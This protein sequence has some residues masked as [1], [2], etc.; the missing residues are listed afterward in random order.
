MAC[1]AVPIVGA[2]A[3]ISTPE[4]FNRT[5]SL[6]ASSDFGRKP[7]FFLYL[8]SQTSALSR[9]EETLCTTYIHEIYFFLNLSAHFMHCELLCII[10]PPPSLTASNISDLNIQGLELSVSGHDEVAVFC[11]CY[12]GM[13]WWIFQ[14]S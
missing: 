10:Y 8:L 1:K 7:H 12:E 2:V 5:V 11:Y 13:A 9:H 4:T 3:V 14:T 6:V